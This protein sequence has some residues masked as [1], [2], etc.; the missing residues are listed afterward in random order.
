M[1][2]IDLVDK[3]FGRWTVLKT[4]GGTSK[5][6]KV[7]CRCDCG[8]EKVVYCGNLTR[9]LSVSCGCYAR[10]RATTHHL[11]TTPEYD[12][13]INMKAR[14]LKPSCKQYADYGGRGIKICKRWENSF[15]NFYADMGPRPS[16]KHSLGRKNNDKGY[17]PS[18]CRWETWSE[19]V[20]NKR[21]TV[22]FTYKGKTQSLTLWCDE[23]GIPRATARTRRVAGWSVKECLFGRPRR[24]ASPVHLTVDGITKRLPEWLEAGGTAQNA[25]VRY[26]LSRGWPHKEALFG[27]NV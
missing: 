26:R 3:K 11:S 5:H 1:K 18:N 20:H 23:L 22:M 13:W 14:C 4:A 7:F 27:K 19:Q 25:T 10:E 24:K 15:E 6:P 16:K 12:A 21:S 8:T 9:T 17:S 2:P